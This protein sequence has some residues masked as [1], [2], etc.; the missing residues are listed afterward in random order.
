MVKKW[1]ER[2]FTPKT[3]DV[4]KIIDVYESNSN[5]SELPIYHIYVLRDQYGNIKKKKID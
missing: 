5:L 1:L 3:W 4:I 2:L